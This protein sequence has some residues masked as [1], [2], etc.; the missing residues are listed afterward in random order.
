[1]PL[2]RLRSLRGSVGSRLH[3]VLHANSCPPAPH[4]HC[5]LFT[6]QRDSRYAHSP[7]P[8]AQ[9]VLPPTAWRQSHAAAGQLTAYPKQNQRDRTW[10]LSCTS[11][12]RH[13]KWGGIPMVQRRRFP[14]SL[15]LILGTIWFSGCRNSHAQSVPSR[16][17]TPAA[18][19][20]APSVAKRSLRDSALSTYNNPN[21]GV[22]FRYP[23]N[24]FLNDAFESEDAAIIEAQQGLAAK[25]PGAML[26][27]IVTIPSDAYPN[28]TSR[29]GTLELVVSPGV[30]TET[31]QSFAAPLE[32]WYAYGATSI[33]GV[34]FD[35]RQRGTA[36]LGTGD[37]K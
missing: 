8:A 11:P 19:S 22:S 4:F 34:A 17:A 25:Q 33:Q 1:M 24:Y 36:A 27:A 32:K 30:T 28:T 3:S 16:Q 21:Y 37:R 15:S 26:V 6:F 12:T 18:E 20:S 13:S 5:P 23:R 10:L 29:A 9:R 31:C 7:G 35:W 14:V 2:I